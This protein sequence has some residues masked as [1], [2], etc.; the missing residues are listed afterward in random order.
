MFESKV[1]LFWVKKVKC[2]SKEKNPTDN[3]MVIPKGKG[4]EGSRRG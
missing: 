3:S 4:D 1:H 2:L